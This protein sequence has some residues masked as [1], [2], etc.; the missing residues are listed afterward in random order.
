MPIKIKNQSNGHNPAVQEM[1]Q[2]VEA[3]MV[4][5]DEMFATESFTTSAVGASEPEIKVGLRSL[6]PETTADHQAGFKLL[7]DAEKAEYAIKS[8]R[9]LYRVREDAGKNL[10]NLSSQR[11]GQHVRELL[12]SKPPYP[13]GYLIDEQGLTDRCIYEIFKKIENTAKNILPGSAADWRNLKKSKKEFNPRWKTHRFQYLTEHTNRCRDY[14]NWLE[15]QPQPE[16]EVHTAEFMPDEAP[17]NREERLSAKRSQIQLAEREDERVVR[18]YCR[19]KREQLLKVVEEEALETR[20][21]V[22]L[23]HARIINEPDTTAPQELD[24]DEDL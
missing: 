4:E 13:R 17:E 21:Q 23:A 11:V 5:E 12:E 8:D 20:H 24:E 3:E 14:Y 18:D 15:A 16:V 22:D 1:P 2:T 10:F 9:S 19:W 7:T 6:I